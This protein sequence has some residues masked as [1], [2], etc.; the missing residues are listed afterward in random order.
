MPRK[1]SLHDAG[2]S[3]YDDSRPV[4]ER[5]KTPDR[6]HNAAP[7]PPEPDAS[8]GPLDALEPFF[9]E[10][11]ISDVLHV[12]KSGKEA[13]VY[14]CRAHPDTELGLLAAKVY[15]ARDDR[16]F[17]N[18]AIYQEGRVVPDKRLRRA[19]EHK[20]RK[21]REAQF[22]L[23]VEH[24]SQTLR[25]LYGAGAQVPVP[26]AVTGNAI[27]MQYLGDQHA[28]APTLS[29]VTLDRDEARPLFTR[30]LRDVELWLSLGR[31]HADLSAFNILYHRERLTVID[32]PQ[33]VDPEV[34]GNAYALLQ[35]DITNLCDYWARY[36]V[37]NDPER[38]TAE[39][40]TRATMD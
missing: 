3:R 30:L 31:V 24:E 17:K 7:P 25:M 29:R 37:R 32:F 34:N 27:L 39:I 23:W 36:G 15:R 14:C 10:R 33:S 35:R 5:I 11:W 12:V 2:T 13:T 1:Q 8:A 6:G 38:L 18:D 28:P 40:W 26:F 20:T 22:R 16:S 4:F 21:G 19:V 9:K